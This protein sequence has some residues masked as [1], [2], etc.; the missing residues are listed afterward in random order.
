MMLLKKY[1]FRN[2]PGRSHTKQV[3]M[4]YRL[5]QHHQKEYLTIPMKQKE[6]NSNVLITSCN[7]MF[8][9]YIK[10]EYNEILV[11]THPLF[12]AKTLSNYMHTPLVCI[13]DFYAQIGDREDAYEIYYSYNDKPSIDVFKKTLG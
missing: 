13:I 4:Y 3:S 10:N 8:D 9:I 1:Y 2:F 11:E 12:I 5:D 6:G 7:P